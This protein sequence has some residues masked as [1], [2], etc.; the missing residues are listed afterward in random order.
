[1]RA[2]WRSGDLDLDDQQRQRD[3]EDRVA[4]SLKAVK[5]A[6]RTDRT[7]NTAVVTTHPFG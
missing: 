3:C 1:M 5:S 2:V 7:T 6:L 4:E